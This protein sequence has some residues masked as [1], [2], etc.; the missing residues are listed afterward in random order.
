[1]ILM[2]HDYQ[3]RSNTTAEASQN[4]RI[5]MFAFLAALFMFELARPIH[6]YFAV[7]HNR[8]VVDLRRWRNRHGLRP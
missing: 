6:D 8:A 3:S 2:K 4:L 1:M 7:K 5:A